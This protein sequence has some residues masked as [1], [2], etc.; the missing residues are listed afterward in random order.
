M[1]LRIE[2][3]NV[4]PWTLFNCWTETTNKQTRSWTNKLE[5]SELGG[6]QTGGLKRWSSH[7]GL[8]KTPFGKCGQKFGYLS[9][10]V[11]TIMHQKDNHASEDQ[12]NVSK[13]APTFSFD[14]PPLAA[15]ANFCPKPHDFTK[16]GQKTLLNTRT[17]LEQHSAP[18]NKEQ[19]S[20]LL[21]TLI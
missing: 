6:E 11:M 21:W 8:Q 19:R 5:H 10:P 4:Q 13:T 20:D 15:R 3:P 7:R 1:H 12:E 2:S 9:A 18:M 14:A 17:T 16:N